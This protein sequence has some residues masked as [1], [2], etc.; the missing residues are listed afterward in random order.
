MAKKTTKKSLLTADSTAFMERYLNNPSPTGFES[1]GQKLWLDYIRP[2]VDEHIIDP[3]GTVVGVINPEAKYRVVIEAHA[4]E[5]SWFVHYITKEGF[6]YVKRNGGSDHMIAPSMRVN[7]HT[8][9][10]IVKAVFGWPAI[11]VR[12]GKTEV[13]PTTENIFLDC[14]CNS[15]AEV[16]K[17]GIHV[18]CVITYED[19]F[20]ILNGHNFVGVKLPFGLYVTNSVQEEVGL[21]GAEMIVE[22][23]KP[24]LAIVTD[25]THDTQTPMMSKVQSGDIACGAGPVLSYAPAV[26]NNLLKH[27]VRTAEKEKIPFQRLAASRAT[28]TDTDAFAY[29][30]A[31]VPSA[32]ISLPLRYMHTTVEMVHKDDVENVIQLIYAAVKSLKAGQDMRY[33]K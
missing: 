1:E 31:G 33:F 19:E 3:Y 17:L 30:G 20:M 29:G 9:K 24:D 10:G 27:I 4:D 6:I 32:L 7:I 11:H 2:Y 13:T 15:K 18:G 23:I 28:G 25:V 12:N 8:D 26:H 16:E 21:R 5:I 14:G 22:R